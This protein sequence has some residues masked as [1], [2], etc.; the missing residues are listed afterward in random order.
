MQMEQMAVDALPEN[1]V[2]VKSRDWSK[3]ASRIAKQGLTFQESALYDRFDECCQ[4]Y[5]KSPSYNAVEYF[6][7]GHASYCMQGVNY[8]DLDLTRERA[9]EVFLWFRAN[10]PHYFFLANT[11]SYTGTQILPHVYKFSADGNERA[12]LSNELFDKLDGWIESVNDDETTTWQKLLSANNLLCK[13]L[14]FEETV[15]P[16]TGYGMDQSIY[17]ALKLES[18]VCASYS[19]T[20]CAIDECL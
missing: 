3:Y 6:D 13:K 1:A 18:A 14:H 20:F 8:D 16:E 17:T 10:D 2:T 15:E 9:R 12:Q 11:V 4:R 7:D 5:L 19:R